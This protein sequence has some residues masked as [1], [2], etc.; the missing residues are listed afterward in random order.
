MTI[1][2]LLPALR[3]QLATKPLLYVSLD[4]GANRARFGKPSCCRP[5][6]D[7]CSRSCR[8]PAACG[9]RGSSCKRA[10]RWSAARARREWSSASSISCF[11]P[12]SRARS[13]ASFARRAVGRSI[14]MTRRPDQSCAARPSRSLGPPFGHDRR[15]GPARPSASLATATGFLASR[16]RKNV[17]GGRLVRRCGA[18][19]GQFP[20]FAACLVAKQSDR[21][22][23]QRRRAALHE[24]VAYAQPVDAAFERRGDGRSQRLETRA[25]RSS[26]PTAPTC[27]MPSC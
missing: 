1:R 21:H 2:R 24:A 17:A 15:R 20:H 11:A 10:T 12:R 23:G 3:K 6:C 5:R 18:S 4:A 22:H 14:P 26:S 13:N 25:A 16:L 27:S 8:G 9:K 7:S 19:R